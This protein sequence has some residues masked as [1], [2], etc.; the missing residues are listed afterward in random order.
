VNRYLAFRAERRIE[1]RYTSWDELLLGMECAARDPQTN[2][3][4]PTNVGLLM[5]GRDP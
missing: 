3:L 2:V 5:F 4:R 1:L